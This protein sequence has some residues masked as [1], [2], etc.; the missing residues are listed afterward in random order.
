MLLVADCM[1]FPEV[2]SDGNIRL[3]TCSTRKITWKAMADFFDAD[4]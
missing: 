3:E 1:N 4:P 2:G